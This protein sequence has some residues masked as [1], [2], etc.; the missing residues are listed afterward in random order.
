MTLEDVITALRERWQ[1]VLGG[2][3]S[4]AILAVLAIL[5][6]PD[7]FAA[8]ARLYVSSQQSTDNATQ[9]YQGGLLS[10]QRVASYEELLVSGRVCG[11]VST[12]LSWRISP[13]E[14]CKKVTASAQPDTVL[15]D[16]VATD[17]SPERAAEIAN[18]VGAVFSDLVAELERPSD[19]ALPP[20]VAARLVEPAVPPASPVEPRPGLYLF[21]GVALG[22]VLGIGAASILQALDRRLKSVEAVMAVTGAPVL[23]EVPLDEETASHVDRWL[24]VPAWSEAFRRTRTALSYLDIDDPPKVLLFTSPLP[25]EGKS[26]TVSNVSVALGTAGMSVLILEADLRRPRTSALLGLE[27]TVGLTTVL[28]GRAAFEDAVQRSRFG[29]VSVL[30][31]GQIPPNPSELLGSRQMAELLRYAALRYDYVL[32]DAPPLLP[33]SDAAALAPSCDAVVFI[34][35]SHKT[36]TRDVE[37]ARRALNASGADISGVVMTM[38][39]L[40]SGESSYSNYYPSFADS[41]ADSHPLSTSGNVEEADTVLHEW[42]RPSP[43]RRRDVPRR[44]NR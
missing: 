8:Q 20:S 6:I 41:V 27:R 21:V 39:P 10:E 15:L 30:A 40:S 43:V 24:T 28:S 32:L 13:T 18:T 2:I 11:E 26:T 29:G 42:P 1:L 38:R 37:A 35:R 3:V 7:Q 5:L 25:G 14:V 36:T 22:G 16:V 34:A 9:A 23:G 44:S 33:V 31:S 12:K 19:R 4:G 17:R